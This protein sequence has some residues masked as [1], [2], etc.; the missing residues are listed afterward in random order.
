MDKLSKLST[1]TTPKCWLPFC[2][3]SFA[4]KAWVTGLCL[5]EQVSFGKEFNFLF[6]LLQEL[7]HIYKVSGWSWESCFFTCLNVHQVNLEM[8][9]SC[10]FHVVKD[11]ALCFHSKSICRKQLLCCLFLLSSF[12]CLRAAWLCQHRFRS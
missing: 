8:I 1:L 11:P 9:T 10:I 2:C 4:H 7:V 6:S 5:C 12:S 3:C